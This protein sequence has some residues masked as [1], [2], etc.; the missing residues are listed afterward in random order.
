MFVRTFPRPYGPKRLQSERAV[1]IPALL[2][3]RRQM[4]RVETAHMKQEV[5]AE[6]ENIQGASKFDQATQQINANLKPQSLTILLKLLDC[7]GEKD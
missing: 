4:M 7:C 2:S 6:E 1:D 3:V 5:E